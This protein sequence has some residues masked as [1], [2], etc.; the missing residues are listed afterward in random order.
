MLVDVGQLLTVPPEIVITNLR[1]DLVLWSNSQHRVYFVELT[2]PW[3]DVMEEAFERKRL[4]YKLRCSRGRTERL[5]SKGLP[6]RSWMSG[7]CGNINC[8]ADKGP[9][10][11]RV[12][13]TPGY[14]AAAQGGRAE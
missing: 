9:G 12:S 5:E 3:E 1:P 11:Q 8:E 4:C 10:N 2:V 13:P 7:L 14:Q 6:N